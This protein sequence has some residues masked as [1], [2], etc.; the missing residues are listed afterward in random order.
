MVSIRSVVIQFNNSASQ[1]MEM[2]TDTADLFRS[3]ALCLAASERLID[4]TSDTLR[5]HRE[6][7]KS[8]AVCS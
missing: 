2:D 8:A 7:R 4:I 3:A 6:G 5:P 1:P